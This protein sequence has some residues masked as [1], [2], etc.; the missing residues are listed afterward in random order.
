MVH[1]LEVVRYIPEACY[2]LL[3]IR[4]LDEEGCWIQVQQGV[5]LVTQG[6]RVILKGD[7]CGGL[8]KLNEENSI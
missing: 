8:Y 5:I 3:S 1:A 4:V 7:K 6:D 2:Y